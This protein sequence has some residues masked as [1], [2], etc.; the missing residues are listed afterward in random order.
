MP[1]ADV[2]RGPFE[3]ADSMDRHPFIPAPPRLYGPH[4][5]NSAGVDLS[6]AAV[7]TTL[8]EAQARFDKAMPH[9]CGPI[10]SGQVENGQGAAGD[11][12]V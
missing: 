12:P 11:Q 4:R 6:Q 3:G 7:R 2:A 1:A 9:A 8:A 5:D 10:L